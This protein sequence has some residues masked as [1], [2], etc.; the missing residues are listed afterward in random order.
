MAGGSSRC[1]CVMCSE[2]PSPPSNMPPCDV[3]ELPLIAA[4][5]P[6]SSS[7]IVANHFEPEV[8]IRKLFKC[9]ALG[10]HCALCVTNPDVLHASAGSLLPA[11]TTIAAGCVL[12]YNARHL[13]PQLQQQHQSQNQQ[14]QNHGLSTSSSPRFRCTHCRFACSWRYDL[15]LHLKQKHGI[16]KKI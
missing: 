13:L 16:H 15:K 11:S 8:T 2:V 14:H 5:P 4:P 6:S 7:I 1:L 3:S 10:R 12:G 9:C